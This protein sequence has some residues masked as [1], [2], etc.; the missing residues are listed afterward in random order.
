MSESYI[1]SVLPAVLHL[2][3]GVHSRGHETRDCSMH[4]QDFESNTPS[5]THALPSKRAL[6]RI[7]SD[8]QG[9]SECLLGSRE[10]IILPQSPC[11]TKVFAI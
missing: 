5:D 8:Y 2:L 6:V 9:N 1:H 4:W 7:E 11:F 3:R 10:S